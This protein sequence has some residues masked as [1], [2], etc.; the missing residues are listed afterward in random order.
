MQKRRLRSGNSHKM[1]LIV[2]QCVAL[3]GFS[4]SGTNLEQLEERTGG[5]RCC[6]IPA[7]SSRE[8]ASETVS[9]TRQW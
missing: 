8:M 3:P 5:E 9:G 6:A 2:L 1:K 4:R 7:F